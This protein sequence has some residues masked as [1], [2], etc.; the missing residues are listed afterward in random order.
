[1]HSRVN[2]TYSISLLL[3]SIGAC[4]ALA[5]VRTVAQRPTLLDIS[6]SVAFFSADSYHTTPMYQWISDHELLTLRSDNSA[7]FLTHDENGTNVPRAREKCATE[8]V[9]AE[10]PTSPRLRLV[11]V[12]TA[13][14]HET[15]LTDLDQT[16]NI[17]YEEG[18]S[19]Q[20]SPG[21]TKLIL[22]RTE[23]GANCWT[24]C[25]LRTNQVQALQGDSS[26]SSSAVW[27]SD[28]VR[29]Y[30]AGTRLLGRTSNMVPPGKDSCVP[31]LLCKNTPQG[32]AV[33]L[34]ARG[35]MLYFHIDDSHRGCSRYVLRSIVPGAQEDTE[36]TTNL[37]VGSKSNAV[38][39][40]LVEPRYSKGHED[41]VTQIR[42]SPQHDRIAYLVFSPGSG[43]RYPALVRQLIPCLNCV[44]DPDRVTLWVCNPDGTGGREIEHIDSQYGSNNINAVQWLPDGKSISYVFGNKL[45]IVPADRAR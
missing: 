16:L 4:V 37:P 22:R 26:A 31:Q 36:R 21:R 11:V 15:P 14:H 40:R 9:R 34:D 10:A 45:W 38:E 18:L 20:I 3:V 2:K 25:D 8:T 27:D 12:D 5:C 30:E 28:S 42:V 33:G 1:M 41:E 23:G 19:P 29:W 35:T 7:R 43:F 6:H 44:M 32:V 24:I 39:A 17:S 13:T